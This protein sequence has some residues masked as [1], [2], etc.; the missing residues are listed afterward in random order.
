MNKRTRRVSSRASSIGAR[1]RVGKRPA[2][3][4]HAAA[5]AGPLD[6]LLNP[7][8]FRALCDPTRASLVACIAKCGRGCSVGEVAECCS[9]DLS[10]VSRHL[11][12]L[13]DAGVL[14]VRKEGRTVFY[15]V[16]YSDLT[17]LLRE[18]A[19]AIDECRPDGSPDG[20]CCA[21]R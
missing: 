10:V 20:G 5:C 4:R 21:P 7:G 17:K 14:H 9:V 6:S 3:P 2:T 8:L 18:L 12:I 11:A 16:C 1:T 13:A 15:A 19:D